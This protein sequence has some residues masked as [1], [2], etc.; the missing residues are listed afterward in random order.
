MM[1]LKVIFHA[2]C[3]EKSCQDSDGA[4]LTRRGSVLS[5]GSP[6]YCNAGQMV[7]LAD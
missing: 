5:H 2:S 7:I 4:E 3:V 6:I 1:L